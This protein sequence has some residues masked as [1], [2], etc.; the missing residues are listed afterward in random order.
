[1]NG[2]RL[3][4]LDASLA[5]CSLAVCAGEAV[6]AERI[7]DAARGQAQRLAVMAAEV[8]AA[9]P[10]P[11]T[12]LDIVAVT[13]GPG[14]FTGLRA[15]LALAHGLALA[16]GARLVGVTVTEALAAA[17]PPQGCRKLWVAVDSRRGR[18]FLD[19]G[20]GAEAVALEALPQ[21]GCAVALAGD[22]AEAVAA[23]LSARG[24]NVLVTEARQP[25]ARHVARAALHRLAA[26]LPLAPAQPIY[27]DPP[28]ARLPGAGLRPAPA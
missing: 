1:M 14:S 7:E 8:L 13:V 18:M 19:R 15:A 11:A 22:A 28:E 21:P 24:C 20:D 27:V 12:A 26:G 9:A 10:F 17:L 23:R 3:L 5:R 25:Q 2:P 16:S 4:A 6:L